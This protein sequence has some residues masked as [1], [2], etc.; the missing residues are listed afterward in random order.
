MSIPLPSEKVRLYLYGVTAVVLTVLAAYKIV[1][2]TA[3]PLWLN[4]AGTILG[5]TSSTTAVGSLSSQRRAK[6]PA[7]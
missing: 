1:D 6:R 3:V 4:L 7:A 5:I 2:A